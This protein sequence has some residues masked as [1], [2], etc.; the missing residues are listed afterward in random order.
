M[1]N[2]YTN[3][4]FKIPPFTCLYTNDLDQ[5]VGNNYKVGHINSVT[6]IRHLTLFMYYRPVRL[7]LEHDSLIY[8]NVLL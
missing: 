4:F 8:N 7:L 6:E 1:V 3:P 5:I 2:S